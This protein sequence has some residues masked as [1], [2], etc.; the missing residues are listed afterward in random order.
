MLAYRL[1]EQAQ[2]TSVDDIIDGCARLPL[3]LAVVAGRAATDRQLS[4]AKV[5]EQLQRTT[6]LEALATDDPATDVRAVLSSSYHALE[7]DAA[8]VFR[9]L[10]RS[11][12]RDVTVE[13]AA[14]LTGLEPARVRSLLADL[15]RVS[16]LALDGRGRY[17]THDLWRAYARELA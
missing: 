5:A 12:L 13:V 15:A 3:A 4:V 11:P 7:P 6:A 10:I 14:L 2:G 9:T 17:F 16:L 1:G 8:Q